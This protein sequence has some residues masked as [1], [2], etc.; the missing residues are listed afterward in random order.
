MSTK[1]HNQVKYEFESNKLKE[2]DVSLNR[3][4]QIAYDLKLISEVA[5]HHATTCET[6]LLIPIEGI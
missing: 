4:L 2:V 6:N 5:L 3:L 1:K